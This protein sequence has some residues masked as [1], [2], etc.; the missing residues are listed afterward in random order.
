MR[1]HCVVPDSESHIS[2]SHSRDTGH[3]Y[4]AFNDDRH[5]GVNANDSRGREGTR[6]GFRG[7]FFG[8]GLYCWCVKWDIG[9][10]LD[11]LVSFGWLCRFSFAI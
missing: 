11:S 8:W 1:T 9:N 10:L 6:H 7:D 5:S 3:V 2:D 4:A